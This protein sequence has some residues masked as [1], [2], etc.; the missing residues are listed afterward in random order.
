MAAVRDETRMTGDHGTRGS[1]CAMDR[2]DKKDFRD[3]LYPEFHD[4]RF[5]I[6]NTAGRGLAGGWLREMNLPADAGEMPAPVAGTHRR[7]QVQ[8]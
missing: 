4:F 1:G 6:L 5:H 2:L 7:R 3:R 8:A